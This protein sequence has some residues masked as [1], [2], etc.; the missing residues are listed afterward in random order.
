MKISSNL[1]VGNTKGYALLLVLIISV[2]TLTI[3]AAALSWCSTNTTISQR[4]N[5]YFKTLA[6]AEAAT[7]KVITQLASDYQSQ[8]DSLVAANLDNYRH[9][10]PTAAENSVWSNYEFKDGQGSI[11]QTY[12]QY[13]PPS[14]FALLNSQ[15]RGLY[16]YASTYRIIS[17]ARELNNSIDIVGALEQDIQVA[18]IPVFQ[19]AIFYNVDLEINPG[20]AMTITGPVHCNATTYLQPMSVLTFNSDVTSVGPIITNKKPTD[21]TV[22]TP[23]TLVFQAEHDAGVSMLNL[24]IG[25]NNSPPAVREI[26]EIPPSGESANSPMGKQRLYNMADLIILV[27][28]NA[29]VAKSGLVNNF[30]T[31]IPA[32]QVNSFLRTNGSFF[33]KRENKTIQTI[34]IDVGKLAAWNASNSLLRSVLAAGDV[35]TVY[36]EDFRTQTGTVESGVRLTNGQNILPKGLTVATPNPVYI[37][38]NYNVPSSALGST[39]TSG[40]LPAAIMA[41]AITILSPNWNDANSHLALTS[42]VASD[43]TVNAA[44]LAGIVETTSGSYSGGVENFPRFLE[45]WS[46]RTF[47]YNGSMVVMYDTKFATGLWQ[48]TGTVIGI[49]NPPIRNWAFDQNFRDPTKLPPSTP[50]LR[51]MIRGTWKAIAPN[52]VLAGS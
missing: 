39:N 31:T 35:R 46:S 5:Q 19:F 28:N 47:T 30:A 49:Y 29:V 15:Y 37:E 42:R 4:N 36:V 14:Q 38:G 21:P 13:V 25:T 22:R 1:R 26:V 51:T 16:G 27:S 48:G 10:V 50:Q 12:V 32:S 7:E 34:D 2:A 18:T 41:D 3:L 52:T 20:A 43:T 8:G 45:N 23:G 40:T 6:A 9:L 33:N 17:N 11:S 44:F 24:P